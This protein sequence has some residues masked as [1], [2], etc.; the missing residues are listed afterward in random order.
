[1][2]LLSTPLC[3]AGSQ[4]LAH[5]ETVSGKQPGSG[6]PHSESFKASIYVIF[7]KPEHLALPQKYLEREDIFSSLSLQIL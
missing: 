3:I 4:E 1:M 5:A 7:H 2:Q 6:S